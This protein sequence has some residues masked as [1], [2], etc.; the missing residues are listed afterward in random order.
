MDLTLVTGD[1]MLARNRT[2]SRRELRAQR[3]V[4]TARAAGGT[5]KAKRGLR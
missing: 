5:T 4:T 1:S 3:L 2:G